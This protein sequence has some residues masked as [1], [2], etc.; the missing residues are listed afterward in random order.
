VNEKASRPEIEKLDLDFS[1]NDGH[2]LTDQLIHPWLGNR[3]V[4]LFV[5]VDPVSGGRRLSI[6]EHR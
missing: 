1:I 6:D 4:A 2:R 5:Y 3:A